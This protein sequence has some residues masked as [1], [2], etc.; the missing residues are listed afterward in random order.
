MMNQLLSLLDKYDWLVQIGA[1]LLTPA[2]ILA[3]LIFVL[4]ARRMASQN[5]HITKLRQMEIS[6]DIEKMQK[7][8]TEM[9][10][11]RYAA[12][13]EA[14]NAAIAGLGKQQQEQSRAIATS[15]QQNAAATDGI[16][17]TL[18]TGLENLDK[19]QQRTAANIATNITTGFDKQQNANSDIKKSLDGY[20]VYMHDQTAALTAAQ[21]RTLSAAAAQLRQSAETL[22]DKL[23][24]ALQSLAQVEE[25]TEGLVGR[26]CANI[27]ARFDDIDKRVQTT[28]D[29]F[30]H[31][32]DKLAMLRLTIRRCR[33]LFGFFDTFGFDGFA[34]RIN[35]IVACFYVR[36]KNRAQG[37]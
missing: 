21:D 34:R 15:L 32:D 28:L 26:I 1:A 2:V 27:N 5:R 14:L 7:T 20:G 35:D 13:E 33:L 18:T 17:K 31:L 19:Q 4:A 8:G 23:V 37:F 24:A 22:D 16:N 29:S 10:N 6:A 30:D 9:I 12:L 36:G 11:Q 25:N 3:A